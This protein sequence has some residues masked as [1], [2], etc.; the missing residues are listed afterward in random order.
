MVVSFINPVACDV[1]LDDV[2]EPEGIFD[3]S[4]EQR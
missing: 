4:R 1:M 2:S 3:S